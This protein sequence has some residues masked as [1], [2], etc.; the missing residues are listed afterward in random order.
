MKKVVLSVVAALAF[1]GSARIRGG[2]AGESEDGGSGARRRR[3]STS[4]S[5]PRSPPTTF[6]A[7]SRSRTAGRRCRA[8]SNSTTLRPPWLTLYAGMWGSSLYTGFA[9]AEFDISGGAR[10]ILGNFGLDIGYVYYAYPD[11]RRAD[12]AFE[13]QLRRSL[14]QAVATRSTDWLTLRRRRSIGGNNFGNTAAQDALAYYAGNA[15]GRRCRHSCR[16]GSAP[17]I[18]AKSAVR[19]RHSAFTVLGIG[20]RATLLERRLAFNYKALTLDLRY[21]DTDTRLHQRALRSGCRADA[22]N[23][24]DGAFVATLKFDTTLSALK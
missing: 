20:I 10:F 18:S 22:S 17:R 3:R 7:A 1:L 14:R 19:P 2:H 23:L 16:S 4:P 11:R 12:T 9:D 5:A 13:H 8:T 6:C 21:F 24:C 15:D